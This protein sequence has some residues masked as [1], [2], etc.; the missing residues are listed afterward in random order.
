MVLWREG[1]L[2]LFLMG[3]VL[4]SVVVIVGAVGGVGDYGVVGESGGGG[5][6]WSGVEGRGGEGH[7]NDCEFALFKGNDS[8][9]TNAFR[10]VSTT[11]R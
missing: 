10:P 8:R 7:W 5:V 4:F 9:V 1:L 11:K 2:V 6:E 3:G